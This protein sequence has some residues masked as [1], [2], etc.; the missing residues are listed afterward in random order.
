MWGD[1]VAGGDYE[2]ENS[3]FMR[4]DWSV[5]LGQHIGRAYEMEGQ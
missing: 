5:D 1:C 3:F 2:H 4:A